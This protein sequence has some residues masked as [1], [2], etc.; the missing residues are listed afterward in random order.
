LGIDARQQPAEDKRRMAA[1]ATR[2][3]RS[4]GIRSREAILR[5]AASLA[6]IRGIEA[7]SLGDLAAEV[8]MSKSGM[9]AHFGSKE[10]LQ[11]ATVEAATEIFE[12]VVRAPARAYPKGRDGLIALSDLFFEHIRDRVFPGGCFFDATGAELQS[13]PGPVRDAVFLVLHDWRRLIREHA[14]AAKANG[15]LA[16][17]DDVD[18]VVFDVLAFDSL[19]HAMFRMNGDE[20]SIDLAKRAVRLRLG[21]PPAYDPVRSR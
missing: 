20:R 17:D 18:Q 7:L 6:S 12:E 19:A 3:V 5:T 21:V 9:Y 11:L 1:P 4:D 16:P 14:E 8:G 13:H 15:E 2:A 10:D